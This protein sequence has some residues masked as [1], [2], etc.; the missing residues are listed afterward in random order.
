MTARQDLGG[1]ERVVG[2]LPASSETVALRA[3]RLRVIESYRRSFPDDSGLIPSEADALASVHRH[4]EAT[5]L[6]QA[7]ISRFDSDLKIWLAKTTIDINLNW[8]RH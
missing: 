8:R 2:L 3:L 1:P 6:L 7:E 5:K 4:E